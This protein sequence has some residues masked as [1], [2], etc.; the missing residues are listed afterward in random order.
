MSVFR[1]LYTGARFAAIHSWPVL[2]VA[3]LFIPLQFGIDQSNRSVQDYFNTG[4]DMAR[5][6]LL[7][8]PY[9]LL[10]ALFDTLYR[11]ALLA[12]VWSRLRK[13]PLGYRAWREWLKLSFWNYFLY[14]LLFYC[15]VI[16]GWTLAML[17]LLLFFLA[18]PYLDVVILFEQKR[19]GAGVRRNLALFTAMPGPAI[20]LSLVRFA[21]YGF[22]PL[23]LYAA[24]SSE[25]MSSIYG[26]ALIILEV[27]VSVAF[28][29]LY[30]V[31]TQGRPPT[32]LEGAGPFD[33]GPGRA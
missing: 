12:L 32:G 22:V 28:L 10:N 29:A 5:Y 31:L 8:S 19:L 27:P 30:H 33:E 13:S 17:P 2:A 16:L 25:S 11:G 18:F 21:L 9:L 6:F 26:Y 1:L 14:T 23:L 3:A 24:E 20:G 15:F 4:D 7:L